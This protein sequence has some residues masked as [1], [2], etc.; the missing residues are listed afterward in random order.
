MNDLNPYNC[1]IPGR[2]FVGFEDLRQEFLAGFRNGNS[3]AVLGGR[4]C[5]KTSL[6]LQMQKDLQAQTD[7]LAPFHP[8]PC[9]LDIQQFN[10]LTPALLFESRGY[11]SRIH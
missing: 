10:E 6:L 8:L 4:R 5:G 2:L 1:T 9:Y 7:V 11:D 3:Y